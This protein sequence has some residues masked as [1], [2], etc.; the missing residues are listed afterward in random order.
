M[1]FLV[2]T[3][4]KPQIKLVWFCCCCCYCSCRLFL[5]L[6]VQSCCCCCCCFNTLL[7][8]K[9]CKKQIHWHAE[10]DVCVRGSS[11]WRQAGRMTRNTLSTFHTLYLSLSLSYSLLFSLSPSFFYR[12]PLELLFPIWLCSKHTF[13]AWFST[14]FNICSV[15]F[16]FGFSFWT[17]TTDLPKNTHTHTQTFNR[18]FLLVSF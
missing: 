16:F 3:C 4:L 6:L 10:R 11:W 7:S 17:K 5:L 14:L 9:A 8:K 1:F 18:F 13:F 2:L 15:R 12:R